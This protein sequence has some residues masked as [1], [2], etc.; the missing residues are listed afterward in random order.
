MSL[1]GHGKRAI[2]TTLNREGIPTFG[3]GKAWIDTVVLQ[4][5]DNEAVIGIHQPKTFKE[6]D[7]KRKRVA[8][9]D[10]IQGYFPEVIDKTTF[11]KAKKM[12]KE[13]RYSPGRASHGFATLFTGLAK[14]GQCGDSLHFEHKRKGLNYLV[15][16]TS[17]NSTGLCKR[18][19]WRYERVQTHIICNLFHELDFRDVLPDI[20]KRGRTEANRIQD[21]IDEK[22]GLLEDLL[23]QIKNVSVGIGKMGYSEAL[24]DQLNSLENNRDEIRDEI[25]ELKTALE[26]A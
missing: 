15:C 22:E 25:K 6:I 24:G 5:L 3:K 1:A 14:C 7:G 11:Y 21:L 13:R 19:G 4:T 2:T 10:P 26:E 12:R 18:H 20:Y 8:D 9:G 17:R 16:A 23:K